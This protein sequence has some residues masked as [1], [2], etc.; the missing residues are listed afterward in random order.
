MR[1]PSTRRGILSGAAVASV[2][3]LLP[4]LLVLVTGGRGC[5]ARPRHHVDLEPARARLTH[6]ALEEPLRIRAPDPHLDAVFLVEG[7]DQRGNVLGRD[8]RVE[9]E[10]FFLFR[11]LD[12]ALLA[13]GPLLPP[14]FVDPPPLAPP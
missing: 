6:D 5:A 8:R 10:L 14:D 12:E 1:G 13:I 2:G 3:V 11:P 7:R 9:R 4:G